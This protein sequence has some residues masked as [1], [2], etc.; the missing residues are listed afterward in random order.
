MPRPIAEKAAADDDRA[1]EHADGLVLE[2]HP[3]QT[4]GLGLRYITSRRIVVTDDRQRPRYLINVI[5]DTTERRLADERIAHLAHYDALTELPNRVLFRERIAHE[6]ERARHGMFFA[7]LYLDID[8][9]KGINDS[10]GHHVGDELLRTIASRIRSC[11]APEDT[12]ARLGGDEFAAIVSQDGADESGEFAA[13]LISVLSAP[14]DIDG[15]ELVIGASIGIA[16]SPLDGT[17]CEELM[18]NADMALYRAKQHGGR[19]HRFFE[20]EM[21]LQAQKRRDMEHDLRR[22]FAQAEFELHYQPLIDVA[23][24][25]IS[26][27]ECL[28]RWRHPDK[29]MISPAEF[30]PVAEDIGLIVPLGEWVLRE[31]CH[32]AATWPD[33][34]K[35]AVNL[36]AVQFRSRN[37]VQVVMQALAQSSLAPERLELEI[38]ESILLAETD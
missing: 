12:V 29:G 33:G 7:L 27:F 16:L 38:T 22:A 3:W 35:V 37:L 19:V 20:R 30:I 26:G 10:L 28:L 18:K 31:A 34:I 25:I 15:N 21:D 32:E 36:S 13:R 9:F 11:L 14:Y 5:E 6:I 1:L 17:S 2:E 4:P 8:E 24:N 23:S